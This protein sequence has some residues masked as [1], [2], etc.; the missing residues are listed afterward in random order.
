MGRYE[1]AFIATLPAAATVISFTHNIGDYPRNMWIEL[2]CTTAD[3]GYAVGDRLALPA[4]NAA[5]IVPLQ[6]WST[7]KTMGFTVGNTTNFDLIQKAT[8]ALGAFTAA[9][10][11]YRMTGYR[12]W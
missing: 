4:T 1:A 12:G 7:Y 10:W 9:N 2:Q 3:I 11:K 6:P 8:G 5:A